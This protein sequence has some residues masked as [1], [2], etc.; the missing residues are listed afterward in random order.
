M[1]GNEIT[2]SNSDLK[3]NTNKK[4]TP[5][6]P[7]GGHGSSGTGGQPQGKAGFVLPAATSERR[8]S[9][10]PPSLRL[11][12]AGLAQRG[13]QKQKQGWRCP[14]PCCTPRPSCPQAAHSTGS[15]PSSRSPPLGS[16]RQGLPTTNSAL[17]AGE[18]LLGLSLCSVFTLQVS[19]DTASP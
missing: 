14:Q 11:V 3:P 15:P 7:K 5:E 13:L 6:R 2:G 4:K 1:K 10:S 17:T 12:G 9:S 8:S 16:V 19:L 18:L